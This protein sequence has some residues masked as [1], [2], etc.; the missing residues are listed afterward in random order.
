MAFLLDFQRGVLVFG[1]RVKVGVKLA[2]PP[3]NQN[4]PAN[5]P[6]DFPGVITSFGKLYLYF[7]V[8]HIFINTRTQSYCF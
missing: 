6:T 3:A 8:V 5:F 7:S 1:S 4:S 2:Y